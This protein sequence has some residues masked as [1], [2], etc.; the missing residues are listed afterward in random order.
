MLRKDPKARPTAEQL[1]IRFIGYDYGGQN[2]LRAT[3]FGDCCRRVIIPERSLEEERRTVRELLNDA[4][5]KRH[6]AEEL[7]KEEQAKVHE[8]R[9]AVESMHATQVFLQGEQRKAVELE[10][11]LRASLEEEQERNRGVQADLRASRAQCSLFEVQMEEL[12]RNAFDLRDDL[13]VSLEEEQEKTRGVQEDLRTS[14][15]QCSLLQVNKEQLQ[16]EAEMAQQAYAQELEQM[17]N[18]CSHMRWQLQEMRRQYEET[19]SQHEAEKAEI[20]QEKSTQFEASRSREL[21]L[22]HQIKALLSEVEHLQQAA[23]RQV[24]VFVPPPPPEITDYRRKD[25]TGKVTSIPMVQDSSQ[26]RKGKCCPFAYPSNQLT[27]LRRI[28]R[29]SSTKRQHAAFRIPSRPGHVI[30]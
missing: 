28:S 5:H 25:A 26:Q 27:D 3:I 20:M 18:Q 7:L 10:N 23:A 29:E 1:L 8:L 30:R 2:K 6:E 17:R 13:C 4:N 16:K 19:R 24:P 9:E 21:Y 15:T 11:D 14:R 12:Q 22:E